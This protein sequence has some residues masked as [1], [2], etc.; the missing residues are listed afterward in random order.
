LSLATPIEATI[1]FE[2]LG[3]RMI[4]EIVLEFLASE[5]ELPGK[6]ILAGSDLDIDLTDRENVSMI[7][8]L[9]RYTTDNDTDPAVVSGDLAKIDCTLVLDP[10]GTESFSMFGFAL[11]KRDKT[12][13][14]SS[15]NFDPGS[16]TRP[17]EVL[18]LVVCE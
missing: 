17:I 18:Y 13:I 15:I 4:P 7:A 2:S 3:V 8:I 10:S 12:N 9:A 11:I 14:I 16:E 5:G 1:N 6:K